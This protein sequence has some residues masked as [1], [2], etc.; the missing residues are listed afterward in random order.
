M[1]VFTWNLKSKQT[2]G[3]YFAGSFVFIKP[4][5]DPVQAEPFTLKPFTLKPFTFNVS[6]FSPYCPPWTPDC[7]SFVLN[8]VIYP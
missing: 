5:S 1:T 2:L 8:R 7:E 4:C 6:I 3:K